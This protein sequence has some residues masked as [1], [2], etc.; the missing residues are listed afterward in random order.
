MVE[1]QIG[2]AAVRA[3]APPLFGRQSN[4]IFMPIAASARAKAI[5]IA[6]AF[7]GQCDDSLCYD[8]L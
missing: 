5:G 3:A 6:L 8:V 7:L 1:A 4:Q 2:A